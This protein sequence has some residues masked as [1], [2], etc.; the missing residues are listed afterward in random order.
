MYIH[1][2]MPKQG[3]SSK[4]DIKCNLDAGGTENME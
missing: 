4:I 2:G 3:E 1:R